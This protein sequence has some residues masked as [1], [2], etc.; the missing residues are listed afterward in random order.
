M[1]FRASCDN[2]GEDNHEM[3][4]F[5]YSHSFETDLNRSHSLTPLLQM[6]G[7]GESFS[8]TPIT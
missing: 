7:L 1:S 2:S 5:G 3:A 8:K 6:Q 4:D